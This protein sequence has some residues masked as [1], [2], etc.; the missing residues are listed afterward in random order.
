MSGSK[1]CQIKGCVPRMAATQTPQG[2]LRNR[3]GSGGSAEAPNPF[4]MRNDAE[5]RVQV[6]DHPR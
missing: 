3:H 4:R 2:F 5:P 1:D 6:I